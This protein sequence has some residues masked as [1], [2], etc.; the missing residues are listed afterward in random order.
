MVVVWYQGQQALARLSQTCHLLCLVARPILF[1]WYHAVDGCTKPPSSITL[2]H[3]FSPTLHYPDLA[4]AVKSL[5]LH[6]PRYD[7]DMRI[8][9]EMTKVRVALKSDVT[10][11]RTKESLGGSLLSRHV[12]DTAQLQ[13][14]AL[15]YLPNVSELSLQRDFHYVSECTNILD[16]QVSP[17]LKWTYPLPA[18]RH[19]IIP[20][21]LLTSPLSGQN[22][23]TTIHI[24]DASS[25][26]R[27]AP[28]IE[29]LIFADGSGRSVCRRV[30]FQDYPWEVWFL[31]L[32][33]LS[34]DGIG[35][36]QLARIVALCPALEDIKFFDVAKD[37]DDDMKFQVKGV[38]LE[39][40]K[41]L[42]SARTTL[43]SLC[44]SVIYSPRRGF[45]TM[46]AYSRVVTTPGWDAYLPTG[47]STGL[48]FAEFPA[49]ERLEVEQLMLYGPPIIQALESKDAVRD[50]VALRLAA[51]RDLLERLPPNLVHLQLGKVDIWSV[52]LR[53]MTTLCFPGPGGRMYCPRLEMVDVEVSTAPPESEYRAWSKLWQSVGSACHFPI[54]ISVVRPSEAMGT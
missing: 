44:Y 3:L 48:S 5:A 27:C 19:L 35:V 54:P 49:L 11:R 21:Q 32:R 39:P 47:F 1:H 41:H 34:I 9:D 46:S 26:L 43:K 36:Q 8:G 7:P 20:G 51:P 53:D 4:A 33:R 40:A 23:H 10:C 29:T 12:L 28:N 2:A 50:D 42:G 25:L 14:L 31:R 38:V 6:S 30:F 15:A 52:V 45:K 13:E 17:W 22:S 18:L 16:S 24:Q 37:D